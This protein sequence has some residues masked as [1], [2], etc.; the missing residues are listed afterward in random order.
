M[1][2][3]LAP[4]VLGAAARR[5]PQHEQLTLPG[6]ERVGVEDVPVER[7]VRL[8]QRGVLRERA[9][10][11]EALRVRPSSGAA[12]AWH[13]AGRSAAMPARTSSPHSSGG[14]GGMRGAARRVGAHCTGLAAGDGG[15]VH[16]AR[17]RRVVAA[18]PGAARRG[19][20]RSRGRRPPTRG[21]TR[22]RARSSGRAG[23]RGTRGPRPRSCPRRGRWSRRARATCRP[24][25]CRHTSGCVFGGRLLHI[26]MSSADAF[27]CDELLRGQEGVHDPGVAAPAPSRRRRGRRTPRRCWRTRCRRRTPRPA[28]ALSTV[29]MIGMSSVMPSMCQ[30]N[31]P[32]R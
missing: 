19:C 18:W 16:V 24:C 28:C 13:P 14:S 12:P 11:V 32:L 30:S 23:R 7:V 17:R 22:A 31:V 3:V 21:G 29:A 1:T 8:H 9:E 4:L 5:D 10:H 25:S 2:H 27:G 15:A 6:V 20:P 26:S